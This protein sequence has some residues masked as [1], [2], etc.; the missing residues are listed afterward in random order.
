VYE[1]SDATD[2]PREV[3][4]INPARSNLGRSPGAKLLCVIPTIVSKHRDGQLATSPWR[5]DLLGN[6][7]A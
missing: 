7:N 5:E 3:L 6:L 2:R 1:A 4:G